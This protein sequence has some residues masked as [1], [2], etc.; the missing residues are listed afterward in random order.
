MKLEILFIGIGGDGVLT[1]ANILANAFIKKNY[2]VSFYPFYGSE[3][4]GGEVCCTL[5]VDDKNDI[6]NPILSSPDFYLV[7]NDKFLEKYKCFGSENAKYIYV[8][9]MNRTL[10]NK[11]II[12]LREFVEKY[13]IIEL[14]IL[15]EVISERFK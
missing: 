6:V 10:K 12:L 15:E 5:K 3:Q 4:R 8:D 1:I 11:N 9:D 7:L 14:D 2:N 13:D